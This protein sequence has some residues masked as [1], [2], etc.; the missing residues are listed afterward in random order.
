V[1]D[2]QRGDSAAAGAGPALGE[3]AERQAVG[4]ARDC[5]REMRCALER[6]KRCDQ[7]G[8]RGVVEA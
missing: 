2:D 3:Q 4:S 8:E 5:D 1:V 6:S 7:G